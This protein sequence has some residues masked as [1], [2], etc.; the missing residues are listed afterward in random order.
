MFQKLCVQNWQARPSACISWKVNFDF[1]KLCFQCE[2]D[3]SDKPFTKEGKKPVDKR[4]TVRFLT[5]NEYQ[6]S[7]LELFSSTNDAD[8]I[9][10][11][12]GISHVTI[13]KVSRWLLQ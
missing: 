9:K 11:C 7:L 2:T 6:N 4:E 5:T 8:Y 13:W 12:D 10:I 1:N 3:A